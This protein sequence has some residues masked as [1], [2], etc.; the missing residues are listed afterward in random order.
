MTTQNATFAGLL[1][2]LF[3][4]CASS[5][6]GL[7]A[8]ATQGLIKGSVDNAN[9]HA[10]MVFSQMNIQTTGS[11]VQNSGNERQ[12]TG[13]LGDSNITVTMSAA[14]SSTT[15]VE[16][17]ASKNALSGNKDLAKTILNRIVQLS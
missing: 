16:V 2:L 4:A 11:S 13:K 14:P 12:L 3:S 15:N 7:G 8:G 17:D 9:Q 6:M 1:C 10:Q 5:T